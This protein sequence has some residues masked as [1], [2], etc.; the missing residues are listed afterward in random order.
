M[1]TI[2]L[3]LISLLLPGRAAAIT[4]QYIP[5]DSLR[6]IALLKKANR[7]TTSD[8]PILFFAREL[9]GTPYVAKTLEKNKNEQ[10]VI[11]LRQ[12][13]CTTYVENVLAL[14]LCHRENKNTFA[15][16]C[17]YLQNIRYKSGKI[18][19]ASRL[20]YFSEWISNHANIGVIH[21][22]QTP[23]PPFTRVQKLNI[24]YM[25]RHPQFYPMLSGDS[26]AMKKIKKME[27]KLTGN[28]IRYIPRD[29][30]VNSQLLRQTIHDGDILA[31]V[32][33]IPGLDTS[34]IGIAVWH[35][36]GLHLLN[37]SSIRRCVVEEPLTL[38]AYMQRHPSQLGIRV[39]QI[40]D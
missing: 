36:D 35:Q 27:K 24:F 1:K 34:H 37:A 14:V 9:R 3:I 23:N 29:Q 17:Y 4:P 32:T 40:K 21:E 22:L 6:V 7:L 12:L 20:H 30:I 33:R 11:N 26:A 18:E 5:A 15:D 19:Y 31:I 8:N 38:R 2:L 39:I 28:E 16:F 10:L 25:S 13:D